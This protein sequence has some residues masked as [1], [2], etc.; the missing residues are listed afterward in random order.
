MNEKHAKILVV[1]DEPAI[2]QGLCDVL[3]FNGFEPTPVGN[4]EDGLREGRTG[5][6]ALVLL[7][8]MLPGLNG[9]EVCAAL[10][11]ELPR[12]PILMLTARGAEDDVLAGFRAGSDDYVTK[13]F[14]ISQL[15]ARVEALLRRAGGLLEDVPEPFMFGRFRVDPTRRVIEYDGQSLELSA[16]ELGMLALFAREQ[17]RIVSRRL[18]LRELWQMDADRVETRT[19][20]MHVAKLRKKLGEEGRALIAT[21]RGEGYRFG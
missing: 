1:E 8:V 17:G 2:Q 20:D 6:Y 9:F 12:L 16:R 10:R 13:P 7:D 5:A 4:G 19:V 11:A 14:S 18:L 21:V 15:M 3:A